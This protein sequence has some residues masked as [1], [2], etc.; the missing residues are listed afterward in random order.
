M[1]HERIDAAVSNSGEA[2]RA[3][4]SLRESLNTLPF[5]GTGKV[6]WLQNCS[7]LGDERAASA[8]AVSDD[9]ASL[10]K[11]L[12]TFSWGN[13][14]LL[15][16]AGKVDKRKAFYKAIEKI[17]TVESFAGLSADSSDWQDKGE[18]WVR[19]A[20][21]SLGKQFSEQA[22]AELVSSAGP[23]TRLLHNEVEKLAL[24]VGDRHTIESEDVAE[25]AV[26]NKTARAFALGDAL[27]NRDLAHLLR[28]LDEEL[29][30]VRL[31]PQKSEIGVLYGLISKV[32]SML[33]LKEMLR[34]GWI[35]PVPDYNRFK[36]QLT[37]VPADRCPSDRRYNPLAINP[38]IL[39]KALPQVAKYEVEEL[40][41][42]MEILLE[43]NRRLVSSGG[44]A[45]IALQQAL[46]QII[47][48]T[49][50]NGA[51]RELPAKERT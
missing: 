8:S 2:L 37:K 31:D 36:Q 35:N 14:R 12:K 44:D 38:Y 43:C 19:Q 47:G 49:T 39:F 15:I 29:W 6:V 9:L 41:N 30:E 21:H 18:A 16:T 24:Y 40:V 50:S 7:F 10:A 23:N 28:C 34:E 27:G 42:A 25:V 33:L 26:K 20:A 3:L 17:G 11:E 13:V 4:A 45:S 5:F 32:R 46:I 51:G 1:D 22:A 48:E